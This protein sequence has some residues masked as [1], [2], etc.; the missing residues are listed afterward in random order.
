MTF[1]SISYSF[2]ITNC[3]QSILKEHENL[4][5]EKAHLEALLELQD[6]YY[7]QLKDQFSLRLGGRPCALITPDDPLVNQKVQEIT[8][9][10]SNT[11]DLTEFWIDLEKM[12]SWV[13]LYVKYNDDTYFPK[14]PSALGENVEYINDVWLFP[15]E[16]LSFE[17]GD[18]E[19]KATLFCSMILSYERQNPI[20]QVE[21]IHVRVIDKVHKSFIGH[22]VVQISYNHEVAILDPTGWYST[23]EFTGKYMVN[24]SEEI[25][26]YF[27]IDVRARGENPHIYRVFSNTLLKHF[28]STDEYIQWMEIR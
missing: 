25:Y 12:L 4:I 18:C 19:D 2:Y 10:W 26:R 21:C 16:T 7:Q 23:S 14:L 11:S 6:K 17:Q 9:D 13:R 3:Y 15:N 27:K 8:G 22:L 24:I 5:E 28:T 20:F 1:L